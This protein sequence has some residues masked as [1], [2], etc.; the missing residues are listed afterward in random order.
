MGIHNLIKFLRPEPPTGMNI[1]GE[2]ATS[3][4]PLE[5]SPSHSSIGKLADPVVRQPPPSGEIGHMNPRI[6]N[7][8]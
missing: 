2:G 6:P 8:T 7:E 5:K 4:L 1:S 3:N